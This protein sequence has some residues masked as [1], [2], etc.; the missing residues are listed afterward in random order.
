MEKT[1]ILLNN[2]LLDLLKEKTFDSIK[3]IEICEKAM[4]HKTT[5]YNHFEDKYEL[6]NY[7]LLKIHKEIKEK[8]PKENN[9][10]EYYLSIAKCY[11]EYIKTNPELFKSII[12][13]R[14]DNVE[15]R[16]FHKLYVKDIELEI[17][18][19]K[20]YD[21]PS[22]YVANF[23]VDGVFSLI[24]EWFITGMKEDESTILNYIK[25]LIKG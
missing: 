21:I 14:D 7:A 23:F 6:L 22:N 9:I 20:L 25:M 17:E 5:F 15:L 2:A 18:K 19:N 8:V 13:D 4:V 24:S 3:V 10:T 16:M 12:S 1:K 11:I